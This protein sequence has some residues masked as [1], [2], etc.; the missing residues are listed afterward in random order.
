MSK[1][2]PWVNTSRLKRALAFYGVCDF[3]A[4]ASRSDCIKVPNDLM[5]DIRNHGLLRMKW[6]GNEGLK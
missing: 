4:S 1:E 2:N 5:D 3:R 6:S